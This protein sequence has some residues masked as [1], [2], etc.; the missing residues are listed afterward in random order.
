MASSLD[1]LIS[2]NILTLDDQRP[3]VNALGVKE[4]RIAAWGEP[5]AILKEW[6]RPQREMDLAGHT[7]LPGLIDT[8]L[9]PCPVGTVQLNVDLTAA[10]SLADVAR[11]IKT[12]IRDTP[13]G[14]PVLAFNFN[15]DTVREKRLPTLAE[16]DEIAPDHPVLVM[17][18]DLHSAMLNTAMLKEVK[19]PAGAQGLV[20][21]G[22]GR[23]SG[24]VEDPAIAG[25]QRQF[26]PGSGSE[27]MAAVQAGLQNA[28][29]QGLT[30]AHVKEPYAHMDVILEHEDELPVKIVPLVIVKQ[31]D[32]DDLP[33]ILADPRLAGRATIAFM[34]DGAPDSK[35]AAFF[36]PY[37]D[38]PQNYG[39]L[40]HATEELEEQVAR[41]H[42]AG[43]QVSIHTCGTRATEQV[44]TIYENILAARPRP[45]HR[46][47]IEHFEM[48]LGNQIKRAVA[49][50]IHLAMQPMFLYLS[51]TETY[52][53]IR[54]LLGRE[55]VER[56]KPFRTI[57]DAGGM[58]AGGSD[59]PV[60]PI[61]PLKGIAAC[62]NHPN[63]AQRIT[64]YEALQMFTRNG[65]CFGFM[66]Q[67]TGTL[68][69]GK[70]ADL[71]VLR[72]SPYQVPRSHLGKIAIA[73]TVVDGEVVY[74][75]K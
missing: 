74:S 48:P 8:H 55:R 53:N 45:D 56:W 73:M 28:A 47:R 57:L 40:Y 6:G 26:L 33:H 7:I 2:G 1:L 13:P 19:L 64:R 4:G 49:A 66:E 52:A 42:R 25:V 54:S 59:A 62:V 58:V 71:T 12:K 15:I 39:M 61:G 69:P 46:H 50:G 29:E 16:L 37:P 10:A 9:H 32:M 68:S 67:K 31:Q 24:A 14:K 34:A 20:K 23:P 3:R 30:T 72:A 44:L 70:A 5:E 75:G 11:G 18:Y 35:T 60:T 38:D 17:V 43:F 22:N 21:D 36:E 51:G 63:P 27:I 65:A 41:C